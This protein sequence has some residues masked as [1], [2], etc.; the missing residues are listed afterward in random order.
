M[1]DVDINSGVLE[2][3]EGQNGTSIGPDLYTVVRA[4]F[5]TLEVNLNDI[6]DNVSNMRG[7]FLH[8]TEQG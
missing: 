1:S 3:K 7:H 8:M 5:Q 6:E 4:A 2:Q